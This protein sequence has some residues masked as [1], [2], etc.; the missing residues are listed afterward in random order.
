MYAILEHFDY[1]WHRRT[2]F[3]HI[4][5]EGIDMSDSR[6]AIDLSEA[7]VVL[8][9]PAFRWFRTPPAAELS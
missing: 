8:V 4:H 9:E 7:A 2:K 5:V 6:F 3:T 1:L